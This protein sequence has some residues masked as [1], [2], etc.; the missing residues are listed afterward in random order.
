[1][2]LD[3]PTLTSVVRNT[4]FTRTLT[5]EPEEGETI[6][7]ISV[8]SS[9]PDTHISIT[10]EDDTITIG[11]MY[12][13]GFS[14]T[15]KY[16]E[17]GSSNKLQAPT[18][19]NSLDSLPPNKD[20]YEFNQDGTASITVTYTIDVEYDSEITDTETITHVVKNSPTLGYNLLTS[21]FGS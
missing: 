9:L 7:T 3:P 20:L 6:N 11:G 16:V 17:K 12:Y 4:S 19:V 21:Y 18:V 8:T 13:S 15:A 14:D 2:T 1:M 5:V 10:V